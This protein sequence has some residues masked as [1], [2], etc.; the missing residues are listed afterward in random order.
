MG[1]SQYKL[2]VTGHMN[3]TRKPILPPELVSL[4]L[5]LA[6][7]DWKICLQ[8]KFYNTATKIYLK[9]PRLKEAVIFLRDEIIKEKKT[10]YQWF[11]DLFSNHT[12]DQCRREA[13]K[14]AEDGALPMFLYRPIHYLGTLQQSLD[15]SNECPALPYHP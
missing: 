9:R 15:G 1:F 12:E 4:I 14:A 7:T 5:L 10:L 6:E 2:F 11:I 8:L 13:S 3:N